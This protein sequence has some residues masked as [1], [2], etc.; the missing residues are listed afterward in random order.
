MNFTRNSEEHVLA[1][2]WWGVRN[3]SWVVWIRGA[4]FE[5]LG[6]PC[7]KGVSPQLFKGA[8]AAGGQTRDLLD[9]G[10]PIRWQWTCARE[11]GFPEASSQERWWTPHLIQLPLFMG[12]PQMTVRLVPGSSLW[13][14][15]HP[16]RV[17]LT[18]LPAHEF[19]PI[20]GPR[21]WTFLSIPTK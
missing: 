4:M 17:L 13:S 7:E 10:S 16:P 21:T 6:A 14:C 18:S 1:W 20:D 8:R 19:F 15:V 3:L 2:Q 11:P 12:S 9:P 5:H